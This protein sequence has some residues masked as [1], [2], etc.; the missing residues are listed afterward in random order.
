MQ[1]DEK[2]SSL[3]RIYGQISGILCYDFDKGVMI[4]SRRGENIFK[5]KDGRWEARFVKEISVD[6]RKKYGSVYA[7]TY[8]EVKE[9]QHAAIENNSRIF[10]ENVNLTLIE[11]MREW[12]NSAKNQLKIST[13]RKYEQIIVNHISLIGNLP[14]K[15]ITS[16]IIARFS[17]RLLSSEKHLSR[18]TVNQILVVLGI[19]LNFAKEHYNAVL[20]SV[21]L[22]KCAKKGVR[23][24]SSSEV[25]ILVEFLKN[26]PD[27]FSF[28]ILL[29]LFT[30]MRIGEICAL[31][32][33][34][35]SADT[36]Q[37]CATMERLK[38][39]SGTTEIV[40]LPPKTA[41]SN[42]VIPIPKTLVYEIEKRRKED[43]F[44]LVQ[45]N[46]KPVEPRLL[47]SKFAKISAQC[48]LS[49]VHFHTL[50]HTFATRC[51]EVGVD[52]KTL[53][54]ILGH[55]DVKT[56]LNKYVHSSLE[57]KKISMDKLVI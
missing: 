55:S 13:V 39:S 41:T 15:F 12:L 45:E 49:N 11:I 38:T 22:L 50:R 25:N 54:E 7:K 42:R 44:V 37:I 27:V 28:G 24:L 2:I 30:G 31:K 56:T 19:G 36:I 48:G 4:M 8:R 33:E 40:I 17:E 23:V 29:A 14:I 5:R 34:N 46:G 35:I 51:I 3:L 52:I 6:G 16:E 18:E 32:W 53:S 57:L 21:H 43:G 20:P 26:K 47:Q 1:N 9:K 10:H